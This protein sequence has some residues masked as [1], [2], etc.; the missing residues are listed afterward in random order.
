[1]AVQYFSVLLC[2]SASTQ[3]GQHILTHARHSAGL[4][5]SP[6]AVIGFFFALHLWNC[7]SFASPRYSFHFFPDVSSTLSY[8]FDKSRVAARFTSCTSTLW[9]YDPLLGDNNT[10]ETSEETWSAQTNPS[11]FKGEA[12]N[13]QYLWFVKK[14]KNKG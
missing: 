1:M 2:A 4:Q 6:P 13:N 9:R 12:S 5:P 7:F 10:R 14:V 3:T 8:F 11:L